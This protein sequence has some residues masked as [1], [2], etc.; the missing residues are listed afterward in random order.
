MQG[1]SGRK[2]E[3]I[4]VVEAGIGQDYETVMTR[5]RALK[6]Q[7]GNYLWLIRPYGGRTWFPV[8]CGK[9]NDLHDRLSKYINKDGTFGPQAELVKYA[10]MCNFQ[11]RGFSIQIRY[12]YIYS[13]AGDRESDTLAR[14]NFALCDVK[15]GGYRRVQLR[16]VLAA[17]SPMPKCDYVTKV[18]M[19]DRAKV[20][21]NRLVND[22]SQVDLDLD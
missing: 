5:I 6:G 22:I 11:R 4:T 1:F 21:A 9:A 17:Y 2:H 20:V 14:Y 3:P 10:V 12:R 19:G 13:D 8:Y 18:F 7:A 16:K 15:N